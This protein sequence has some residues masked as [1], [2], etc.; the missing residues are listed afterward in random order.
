MEVNFI[1]NVLILVYHLL[2]ILFGEFQVLTCKTLGGFTNYFTS[3]FLA[4]AYTYLELVSN[5]CFVVIV[6]N[7]S[8]QSGNIQDIFISFV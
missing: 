1:Y 7:I 2:R 6:Y 3:Y 8:F 4:N 5:K